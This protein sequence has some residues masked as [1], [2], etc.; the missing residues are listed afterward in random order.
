MEKVATLVNGDKLAGS[1]DVEFNA[2]QLTSGILFPMNESG[3][4][5]QT[6]K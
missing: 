6:R 2:A 5:V 1:Y 4:F 3:S